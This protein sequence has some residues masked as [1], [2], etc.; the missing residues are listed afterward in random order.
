MAYILHFCFQSALEN[1][2][3]W[4]RTSDLTLNKRRKLPFVDFGV[5]G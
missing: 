2:W 5:K 1:F 4:N 3:V